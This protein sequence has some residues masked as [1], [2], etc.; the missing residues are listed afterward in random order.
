MQVPVGPG[1]AALHRGPALAAA[2]PAPPGAPGLPQEG[3]AGR[4][5]HSSSAVGEPRKPRPV[6]QCHRR[7]G[8]QVKE[9]VHKL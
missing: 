3:T 1:T 6:S 8:V 7:S 2:L 4:A 9:E 5:A